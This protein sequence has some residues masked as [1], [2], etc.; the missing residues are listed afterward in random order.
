MRG[1]C[2]LI[3]DIY[4]FSGSNRFEPVRVEILRLRT[5]NR[6]QTAVRGGSVR[7]GPVQRFAVQFGGSEPDLAI[8]SALRL[9]SSSKC[10]GSGFLPGLEELAPIMA[11]FVRISHKV[12]N[13]CNDRG[14][15]VTKFSQMRYRGLP[16][17]FQCC[18]PKTRY[19]VAGI[20][21]ST[22]TMMAFSY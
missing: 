12:S 20:P 16:I 5:E 6:T 3:H 4:R 10:I 15:W 8:T 18:I 9:P 1:L 11:S 19:Y 21:S 2:T 22:S 14:P 13:G 7:W 17:R